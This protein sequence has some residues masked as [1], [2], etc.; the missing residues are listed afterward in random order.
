[1]TA[2]TFGQCYYTDARGTAAGIRAGSG[3]VDQI[4]GAYDREG[5]H[6]QSGGME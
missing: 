6:W 1:M 3:V 2:L 5:G 4:A